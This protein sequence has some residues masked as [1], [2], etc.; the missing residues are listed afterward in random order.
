MNCPVQGK[1]YIDLTG[2]VPRGGG[3][4]HIYKKY[5]NTKVANNEYKSVGN[6]G[7][8]TNC[9]QQDSKTSLGVST[10]YIKRD[11]IL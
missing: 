6:N 1:F 7:S 11:P 3:V 10:T 2:R 9:I 4:L 5:L 8:Q